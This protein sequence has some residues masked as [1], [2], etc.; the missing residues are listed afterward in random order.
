MLS[1]HSLPDDEEM[2]DSYLNLAID[3]KIDIIFVN[4]L[5]IT[6]KNNINKILTYYNFA[7]KQ[8]G[9]HSWE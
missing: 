4:E 5:L 9:T 2:R 7:V 1:I 6:S 8:K 3:N